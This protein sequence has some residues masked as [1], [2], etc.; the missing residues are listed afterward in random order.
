MAVTKIQS[1][2]HPQKGN[3]ESPQ[4]DSSYGS[5]KRQGYAEPNI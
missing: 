2:E 3:F 4:N 1:L 5:G